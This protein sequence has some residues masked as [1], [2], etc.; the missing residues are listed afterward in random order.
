MLEKYK[1]YLGTGT[2]IEGNETGGANINFD[3]DGLYI[4]FPNSSM[5][6]KTKAI[7]NLQIKKVQKQ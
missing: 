2:V 1:V 5:R 7:S 6:T 4:Y 3:K